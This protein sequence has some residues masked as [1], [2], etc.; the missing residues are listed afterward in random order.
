VKETPQTE[1]TNMM[2]KMSKI[3]FRDQTRDSNALDAGHD[4]Q[5][6]VVEDAVKPDKAGM[7][8]VHR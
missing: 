4:F 2:T 1:Q 3:F 6:A 7:V 8:V 5:I